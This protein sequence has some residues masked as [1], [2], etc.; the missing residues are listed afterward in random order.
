MAGYRCPDCKTRLVIFFSRKDGSQVC[1]CCPDCEYTRMVDT[2]PHATSS[3]E[4][5]HEAR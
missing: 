1:W 4:A 2:K 5:T 3:K